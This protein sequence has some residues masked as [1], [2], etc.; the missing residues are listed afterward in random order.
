[1]RGETEM[2]QVK[3]KSITS[4]GKADVFNMEVEDTHNYVVNGGFVAHNCSDATRYFLMKHPL[5]AKTKER[6]QPKQFSPFDD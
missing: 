5:K 6:K 2:E 1:M 3:I 4:A